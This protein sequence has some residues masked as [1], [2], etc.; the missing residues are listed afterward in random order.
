MPDLQT[1]FNTVP[2]ANSGDVVTE[3][4]HNSLRD[5]LGA[6]VNQLSVGIVSLTGTL[7]FQ[8]AFVQN[9]VGPN[10]L[11]R[12]GNASLGSTGVANGWLPVQFPDGAR[13][14]KMTVIGLRSGSIDPASGL[15]TITLFRQAIVDSMQFAALVSIDWAKDTGS[16][17]ISAPVQVQGAGP[18]DNERFKLVDNTSYKFYI[19]ADA[20][21]ATAGVVAE[22]HSI[23]VDYTKS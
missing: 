17:T 23:R 8:P 21:G 10:W 11:Q 3:E 15:Y 14:Q 7:T 22:I 6:V 12:N 19:I 4:Y 20:V 18:G 13:I 1:L 16:N 5:T 9:N 2:I